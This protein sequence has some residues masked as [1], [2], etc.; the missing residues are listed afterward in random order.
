MGLSRTISEI[1]GDFIFKKI[2]FTPRVFKINAPAEEF[3]CNWASARL[4]TKSQNHCAAG[5]RKK[6]DDIFNRPDTI[7][8]R[9][10]LTDGRTDTG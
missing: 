8:E 1:N 6:F 2:I 9:D 5:P 3:P 4:E 7:H 10:G